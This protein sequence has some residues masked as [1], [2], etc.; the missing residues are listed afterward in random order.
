MFN[1]LV[2]LAGGDLWSVVYLMVTF[3]TGTI[4]I[5]IEKTDVKAFTLLFLA[6]GNGIVERV[7]R[8]E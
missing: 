6:V 2:M 3:M 8:F 1:M 4:L 7:V 5:V